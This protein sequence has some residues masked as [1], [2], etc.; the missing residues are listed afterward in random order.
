MFN[1]QDNEFDKKKVTNL[2]SIGVK[3]YPSSDNEL[4]IKKCIYDE[5]DKHKIVRSDQALQIYPKVFVGIDTYNF[6]KYDKIQITDTTISEYPN[7]G[8]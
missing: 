6:T 4:A 7:T 5:L 2:D 1:D 3:R 8:G